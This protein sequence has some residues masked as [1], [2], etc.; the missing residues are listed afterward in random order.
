MPKPKYHAFICNGMKL[1]GQQDGVCSLKG[2][3]DIFNKFNELVAKYN[4]SEEV[5]INI[6]DCFRCKIS[7]KGPN[8]V[9]YPEGVWYCTVSTNDVEEI[10]Q[11]HFIKG[12]IVER[13]LLIP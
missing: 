1:N 10:V 4:L 9:V 3:S 7:K 2:G 8:M 11:S 12:K 6:S 5:F 13:L